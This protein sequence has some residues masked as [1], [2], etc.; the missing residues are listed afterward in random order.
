M[1]KDDG[2]IAQIIS[3]EERPAVALHLFA[4]LHQDGI[5]LVF[6]DACLH[7]RYIRV[8]DFGYSVVHLHHQIIERDF[9]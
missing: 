8:H 1:H 3:R 9:C 2:R 6:L 5:L 7:P 4:Y